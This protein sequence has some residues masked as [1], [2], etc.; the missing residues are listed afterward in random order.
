MIIYPAIDLRGGQ[1]VRLQQGDPHRQT[2]YSAD[3]LEVARRWQAAGA[4]WLHIVNLDG[5]FQAA[6]DNFAIL[7]KL[8]ALNLHIQFGGGIRTLNDAARALEA[9]AARVVLGTAVVQNPALVEE[10]IARWDAER[11]TV[12]LDARGG[13]VAT[14][15]WQTQSDWTPADLGRELA[16]RG[17][18]HAL[19]T[20]VARDG[21]LEG[22]NVAGTVA[23]AEA[24]G[25]QVI[26]S[27]GVATLEDI[28]ALK[29]TGKVA[30]AVTGKALYE[31]RFTLEEALQIAA[32]D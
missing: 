10:F 8:A 14:H 2:T 17:A 22:V 16:R 24:T 27:G 28:R 30:G 9:G 11:L 5:A 15:G 4:R 32:G 25:L 1:V 13:R 12:A 31:G 7:E 26:A 18:I 3:P 19:Y 23:L 29:A 6:N 20:D 21:E